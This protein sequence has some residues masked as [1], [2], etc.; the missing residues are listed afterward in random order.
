MSFTKEFS[1]LNYVIS[2]PFFHFLNKTIHLSASLTNFSHRLD[3]SLTN[4]FYLVFVSHLLSLFLSLFL[5]SSYSFFLSLSLLLASLYF[6]PSFLLFYL[7]VCTKNGN[8]R[9]NVG[10]YADNVQFSITILF[11]SRRLHQGGHENRPLAL[12]Q[13]AA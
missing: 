13:G 2:V 3:A 4:S 8:T 1:L 12:R 11:T 5:A 7:L 10:Y 9:Y 6:F